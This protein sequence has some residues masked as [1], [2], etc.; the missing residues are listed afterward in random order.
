MTIPMPAL[1]GKQDPEPVPLTP[2]NRYYLQVLLTQMAYERELGLIID[3]TV[4]VINVYKEREDMPR[5]ATRP[6][7]ACKVR[8]I[9]PEHL[10]PPRW[11]ERVVKDM[12]YA[13]IK[14]Q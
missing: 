14:K 6:T 2:V 13:C 12:L 10:D 9:G 4:R 8:V 1:P 7:Y 3:G 5:G 11:P